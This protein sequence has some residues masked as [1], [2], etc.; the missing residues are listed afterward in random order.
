MSKA[1]LVS[2]CEDDDVIRDAVEALVTSLGYN[3]AAFVSAEEYLNSGLVSSTSCLISDMQM[4]GM[5]GADLQACLIE[6]GRTIPTI[7]VT[8]EPCGRL[9]GRLLAAG[10]IAVLPKPFDKDDFV[11]CLE[12]ALTR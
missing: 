8:G 9:R 6:Q 4:P 5:S 2:I 10:A 1:V 11:S 3:T 7:F 12:R